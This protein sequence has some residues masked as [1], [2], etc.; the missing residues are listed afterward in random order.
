MQL[1]KKQ[2]ERFV[3]AGA[4][5]SDYHLDEEQKT[6]YFKA[7]LWDSV[8]FDTF[9]P[10]LRYDMAHRSLPHGRLPVKIVPRLSE[11]QQREFRRFVICAQGGAGDRCSGSAELSDLCSEFEW[12]E[13][14][15]SDYY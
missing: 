10:R 4:A 1:G 8:N 15:L 13:S 2:I 3:R 14:A 9:A 5:R 7:R 6:L 12:I 11:S